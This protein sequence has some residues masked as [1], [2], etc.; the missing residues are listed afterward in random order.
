LKVF[1]LTSDVIKKYKIFFLYDH[2]SSI[3]DH[4]IQEIKV[5][6]EIRNLSIEIN[7]IS[8]DDELNQ[9]LS[10]DLFGERYLIKINI[11]NV[12]NI[13]RINASLK[14]NSSDNIFIIKYSKKDKF[15]FEG[16]VSLFIDTEIKE[17]EKNKYLTYLINSYSVDLASDEINSIEVATANNFLALHNVLKLKTLYTK[18]NIENQSSYEGFDIIASIFKDKQEV[19]IDKVDKFLQSL[20]DP[21]Q[22]NSLLFW[23]FKAVYRHKNDSSINLKNLRLFGDLSKFCHAASSKMSLKLLEN[24]IQKIHLVDKISKGQYID[25]DAKLEIKKILQICFLKTRD[26]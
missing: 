7:E 25:L 22:F 12:K 8:L 10:S 19:F 2:D 15:D 14:E 11:K 26:G 6:L 13:P 5:N 23:F 16:L 24:I 9:Y 4:C 21:I 3:S 20:N 18:N 17:F 1:D